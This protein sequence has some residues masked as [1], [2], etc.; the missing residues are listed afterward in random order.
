MWVPPS[1]TSGWKSSSG[2]ASTHG[3]NYAPQNHW[4]Q[5]R[6]QQAQFYLKMA[7]RIACALLFSSSGYSTPSTEHGVPMLS[8]TNSPLAD[9]RGQ[10][11]PLYSHQLTSTMQ[12]MPPVS[13]V[14]HSPAWL[15]SSHF[16]QVCIVSFL[17]CVHLC[18]SFLLMVI[19]HKFVT[20]PSC[21]SVELFIL[22]LLCSLF[23]KHFSVRT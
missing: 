13:A 5:R 19:H 10:C 9:V 11:E 14:D 6:N 7:V 17:L 12:W 1:R 21:D 22:T 20:S 2:R 16:P 15:S 8:L 23:P 4:H 3:R 18:R